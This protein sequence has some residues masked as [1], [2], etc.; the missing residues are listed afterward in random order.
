MTAG[1]VVGVPYIQRRVV[2]RR[3]RRR[4]LEFNALILNQFLVFE[5]GESQVE[6]KKRGSTKA[7]SMSKRQ[8]RGMPLPSKYQDSV[9]H[10]LKPKSRRH[11]STE[12]DAEM[13]S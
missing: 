10:P 12:I 7:R 13:G 5:K 2:R 3:R 9:L 6:L 11:R 8:K 1:S 4:A